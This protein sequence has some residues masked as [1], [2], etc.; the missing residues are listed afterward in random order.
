MSL[1]GLRCREGQAQA[2]GCPFGVSWLFELL[3]SATLVTGA[4]LREE[5]DQLCS[6]CF[7]KYRVPN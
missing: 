1:H 3:R 6:L 2:W 7:Q 5:G 4:Q